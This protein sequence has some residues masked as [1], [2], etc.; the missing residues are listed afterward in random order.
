M[1]LKASAFLAVALLAVTAPVVNAAENIVGYNLATVPAG[2]DA[3]LSVPFNQQ[4]EAEYTVASTLGSD[5]TPT[6]AL[7][8]LYGDGTY[9][10]RFIDG[11]GEGLWATITTDDGTMFTLE[12]ANALALVSAGDKFRVY[13][14]HTINSLFPAELFGTSFVDGT[15]VQIFANNIAV[16]EQ[17]KASVT[18]VTYFDGFGWFDGISD[19][20]TIVAPETQFTIRNNS[21]SP[22]TFYAMGIA[23]DYTPSVVL[24]DS[25]DLQISSGLPIAVRLD[26]LGLASD[27]V[28]ESEGREVQFFDNSTA[29]QNKPSVAQVTYFVG[30]GWFDG[31][32]DGATVVEPSTAIVFRV[33]AGS[34]GLKVSV[35]NPLD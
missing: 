13:K 5:V 12:N 19:G 9:Y 20:N 35:V 3:L 7:S 34:A 15:E 22:L 1:K 26:L 32:L 8:G 23:A 33:P 21:G 2:G 25:G 11:T 28:A 30:F 24:P 14:H 6:V 27:V 18:A 10:V 29:E 4:S 31:V 17:N 16:P